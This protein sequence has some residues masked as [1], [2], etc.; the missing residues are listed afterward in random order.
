MSLTETLA[1]LKE[2]FPDGA[3]IESR[4]RLLE[5]FGNVVFAGFGIVLLAGIVGIVYTII[6]KMVLAGDQPVAGVLLAAFVIFAAFTLAYVV[7]RESINEKKKK[8][9]PRPVSGLESSPHTSVLAETTFE[10]IQTV[11]EDTTDILPVRTGTT[12]LNEP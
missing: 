3:S 12:K 8:T 2:Q 10:P 5:R 1:A 11:V 9:M 7:M 4:E 6:T